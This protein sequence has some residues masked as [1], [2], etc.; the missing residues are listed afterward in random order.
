MLLAAP[1]R[2]GC[3][4]WGAQTTV[5]IEQHAQT[6]CLANQ[7]SVGLELLRQVD[8]SNVADSFKCGWNL[9]EVGE[10][11]L[12]AHRTSSGLYVL[13]CSSYTHAVVKTCGF[14]GVWRVV[15]A[16]TCFIDTEPHHPE[17]RATLEHWRLP[18]VSQ[19]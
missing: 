10:Q 7:E 11:L 4:R 18:A 17:C 13:H 12:Q 19:A 5:L 3:D 8:M 2:D 1:T 16:G 15:A 14:P 9:L 6:P